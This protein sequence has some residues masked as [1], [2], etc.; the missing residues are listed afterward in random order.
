MT[1]TEVEMGIPVT[2]YGWEGDTDKF[3]MMIAAMP[4]GGSRVAWL[5]TDNNVYVATL[6][7]DDQLV[8]NPFSFPAFDLQDIYAD[9][10]GGVVLLTRDA[11]NGGTDNC[12]NGTLCGGSSSPCRTMWMVRFNSSG[13]VQWETQV[14]NLSDSLAGYDNGARFVWWY[15]HHGRLAFDGSNYA[16]YFCIGITVNNGSCVDIHEGDRMQVVGSDGSPVSHPDEFEVGCSHSWG[17]R[18]VWDPRTDHFVMV[19]ATDNNCR[20]AQP[21]PY[22]TVAQGECDGSLFGGD[23]VLADDNNGYWTAWSQGGQ[24]RLEHFTSGNQSDQTI[25]NAGASAHP[26]LV[27][28]GQS[29]MLLTWESGSGMAAQIRSA[30]DG[31]TVGSEFNIDISDHDFGA[32]KSYDDGSVAYAGSGSSNSSIRIARVMPCN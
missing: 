5:G 32:W 16:A 18:M 31:A 8:G 9:D 19:C 30:G 6:D 27:S 24:I 1:V 28:F 29:N 11:A 15:Q 12:G 3:P 13:V 2:G 20:I 7:C 23:L 25:S 17:T 26:H 21:S 14:T 10:E 4:S 22:S